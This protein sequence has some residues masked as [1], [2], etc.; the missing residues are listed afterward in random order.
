MSAPLTLPLLTPEYVLSLRPCWSEMKVREYSTQ[1]GQELRLIDVLAGAFTAEDRVWLFCA[2]LHDAGE[3]RELRLY[4]CECART[5]EHLWTDARSHMAVEVS[6]RYARGDA[7]EEELS[8]ARAAAYDAAL[9]AAR[10]ARAAAYDAALAAA[11]A[12]RAAAY[13][14][15]LAAARAARA[16]AR[17]AAGAAYDAAYAAALAAARSA[18]AAAW[19]KHLRLAQRIVRRIEVSS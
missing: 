5:V 13:D 4:A 18:R 9:A 1:H 11:R 16:A 7:T 2:V 6:E 8:A 10:A 17:A 15:A 3:H 12:A 19:D 14:A